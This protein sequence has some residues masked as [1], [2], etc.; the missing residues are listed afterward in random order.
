MI[1]A[2]DVQYALQ[3]LSTSGY[4]VVS[5]DWTVEPQHAR[6]F[7]ISVYATTFRVINSRY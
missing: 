6:L 4:E 1:F 5:L 2:K 3:E 7:V